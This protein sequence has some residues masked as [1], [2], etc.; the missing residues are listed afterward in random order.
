MDGNNAN[1]HRFPSHKWGSGHIFYWR[2]F[3]YEVRSKVFHVWVN[4][5][6]SMF[7]SKWHGVIDDDGLINQLGRVLQK[8]FGL[9]SGQ[10]GENI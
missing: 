5:G 6:V 9:P 2:F 10:I 7:I 4:L 8:N 1:E 3:R